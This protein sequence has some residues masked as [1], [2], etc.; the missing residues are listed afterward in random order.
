MNI[1]LFCKELIEETT[2]IAVD[3]KSTT[4]EEKDDSEST[5]GRLKHQFQIIQL[6]KYFEF[7]A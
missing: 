2:V 7:N 5:K 3:E 1:T 6:W 4:E